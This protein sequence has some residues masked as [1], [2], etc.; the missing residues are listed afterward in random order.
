MHTDDK[1][2]FFLCHRPRQWNQSEETWMGRERKR[3]K[4][5]D[6][7]NLL[8]GN[9]KSNF[10]LIVGRTEILTQVKYVITLDSDT[11]LPRESAQQ[12]VSVMVHPLNRPRID[13][14]RECV[15][16][17][18]GILQPRVSEALPFTGLTR[19][20]QLC[21]SEFGIDP[22]TRTVS[23]VYQDIF[24]E[25][26]FMGKG[27]YDVDVFQ[28]VLADRF[29]DNKILSH[30][31]LEGCYLH[32]GFLSDVPLYEQYPCNYLTDTKRRIRWIRG[33]WQLISL[34][35]STRTEWQR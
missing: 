19:Y 33:D 7:N 11:Q 31:L 24:H 27:I 8:C 14:Q 29:P 9:N 2:I 32:S 22:Y 10:S 20:V 28:K 21:G 3:G 1:D 15:V 17:G 16:E 6:L 13:P 12:Y 5:A 26:S 35:V 30:D 18:Y 34:V 4:L 23:D 25:G